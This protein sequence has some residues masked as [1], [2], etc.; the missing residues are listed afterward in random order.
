VPDELAIISFDESDAFDFFYSPVTYVSQ[1]LGDIGVGA[2]KLVLNKLHNKGKKNSDVI[3]EAK[4][5]VR[6]SCG[7]KAG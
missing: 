4:L 2:V 3:V 1:S 5:I 7:N 6:E